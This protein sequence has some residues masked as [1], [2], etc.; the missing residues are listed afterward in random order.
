MPVATLILIRP[1]VEGKPVKSDALGAD[2]DG[3]HERANFAIE[4]VLVH[5]KVDRGIAKAD[6]SWN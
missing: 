6:E 2:R 5:T 4:A 1:G 3:R